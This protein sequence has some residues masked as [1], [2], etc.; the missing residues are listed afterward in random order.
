MRNYPIPSP[1]IPPTRKILHRYQLQATQLSHTLST[2]GRT[3]RNYH[4]QI[5]HSLEIS[6][7][8]RYRGNI[9]SI[10]GMS[11]MDKV[12]IFMIDVKLIHLLY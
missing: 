11:K 6:L 5:N 9:C 2:S 1:Q 10:N 12:I 7:F 4:L 8:E 3:I